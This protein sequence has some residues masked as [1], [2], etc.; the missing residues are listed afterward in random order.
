MIKTID[1]EIQKHL[2][3]SKESKRSFGKAD[4]GYYYTLC[5]FKNENKGTLEDFY[6]T[7]PDYIWYRDN[8]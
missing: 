6:K 2:K 3:Y 4:P 1:S 7:Y 5:K 8:D